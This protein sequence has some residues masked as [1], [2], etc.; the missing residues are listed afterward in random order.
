MLIL[1]I[2]V[3]RVLTIPGPLHPAGYT[4]PLF[5]GGIIHPESKRIHTRLAA[6]SVVT[7]QR[8]EFRPRKWNHEFVELRQGERSRENRLFRGT[9]AFCFLWEGVKLEVKENGRII[10]T[11]Q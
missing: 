5:L 4:S 8:A 11:A 1:L 6:A 3:L 7:P 10:V 2:R 9:V